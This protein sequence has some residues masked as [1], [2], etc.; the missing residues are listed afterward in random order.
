M[1]TMKQLSGKRSVF[2]SIALGAFIL[3][4]APSEASLVKFAFDGSISEV[5]GVLFPSIGSGSMSGDIT[6]DSG[7]API[8]PGTGIYLNSI[9]GLNVKINNVQVA[10]Y[11][12]GSNGMFI[13]NSPQGGGSDN[14]TA[15]STVG[16][17]GGSLV[18][19]LAPVSFGLSL[20]DPSGNVFGS[21]NIPT[22]PPNLSSFASNQWRLNFGGTGNYVIGSL[23][24]LT[25]TAVPLP[26][27]VVLFGIGLISLVGLGAGGLRNLRRSQA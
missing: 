3:S 1:Q 27:A 26:A 13:L 12:S 24:N 4:A 5:G 8:A 23:A 21:Q 20:T 11:A 2:S 15:F 25:L 10:S 6:F 19:G 7:T 9:T 22:V 18:N 17:V 16:S 14:L